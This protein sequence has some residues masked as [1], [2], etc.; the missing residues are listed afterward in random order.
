MTVLFDL[1]ALSAALPIMFHGR[2]TGM[3]IA[4]HAHRPA[5]GGL[6]GRPLANHDR[7]D[8]CTRPTHD[9]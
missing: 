5:A 2:V 7:I 9:L 1:E 3:V 4:V 8:W 6:I